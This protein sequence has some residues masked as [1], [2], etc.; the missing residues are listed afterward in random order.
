MTGVQTCALP[1]YTRPAVL[2]RNLDVPVMLIHGEQDQT[3]P[4]S[5]AQKLADSFPVGRAHLWVAPGAGH[6]DAS[7]QPGPH[8]ERAD[9]RLVDF[10]PPEPFLNRMADLK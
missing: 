3:F 2:A 6:S 10:L 7:H 1:I 4:V 5:F 9:W 8:K